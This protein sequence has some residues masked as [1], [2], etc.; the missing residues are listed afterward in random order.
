MDVRAAEMAGWDADQHIARANEW[1]SGS[2]PAG[3]DTSYEEDAAMAQAH[4]AMA[5]FLRGPY[6]HRTLDTITSRIGAGA[7]GPGF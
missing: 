3:P 5:S 6:P 4:I 1:L 7:N 2:G